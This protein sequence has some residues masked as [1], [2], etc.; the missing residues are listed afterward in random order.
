MNLDN[1][2]NDLGGFKKALRENR[3]E[4]AEMYLGDLQERLEDVK[5]ERKAKEL[6][7]K[8]KHRETRSWSVAGHGSFVAY[9]EDDK[10]KH[11]TGKTVYD[12]LIKFSEKHQGDN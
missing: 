11:A 5:M 9:Q 2:S 6:D 3:L 10:S 1:F 4:D 7:V 12:A 8:V